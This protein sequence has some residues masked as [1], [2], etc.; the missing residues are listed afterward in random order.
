MIPIEEQLKIAKRLLIASELAF[1]IIPRKQLH[2]VFEYKDT[3]MLVSDIS[4]FLKL[5]KDDKR[6]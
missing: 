2:R 1:N 6:D 4:E 3:Y 5:T